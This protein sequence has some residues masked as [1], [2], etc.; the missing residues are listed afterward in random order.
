MFVTANIVLTDAKNWAYEQICVFVLIFEG[1][2]LGFYVK[3]MAL[4]EV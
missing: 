3:R 2:L 1:C 4:A